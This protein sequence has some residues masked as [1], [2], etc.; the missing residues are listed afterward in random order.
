MPASLSSK[1]ILQFLSCAVCRFGN[2]MIYNAHQWSLASPELAHAFPNN[3][4]FSALS[5]IVA[6]IMT[7]NKTRRMM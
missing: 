7:T 1:Q 4:G 5:P 6:M 2:V 3:D